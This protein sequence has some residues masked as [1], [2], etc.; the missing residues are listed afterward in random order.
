MRVIVDSGSSVNVI[1]KEVLVKMDSQGYQLETVETD[2]FGFAGHAV[3]PE[4]EIILPLT[5]GTRELRKMV[6]TTFT[7]VDA[8]S[9]YNI[10]LG[11]PAMNK[12]KAVASTY[13]QKI[14]FPVG[15]QEG[16]AQGDQ[17]SSQKCYVEAV[18]VDQKKARREEK[19]VSGSEEMERIVEKGKV[20]FVAEEEQEVVEIGPDK[21]IRVA[22]DLDLSTRELIG[23]SPLIAEYHLNI[24]SGSQPIKQKKRHFGP[25]KDKVIDVQATG[26]W[27][28]CVDFRDLNKACPKDH[29]PLPRID[30]LV[31][32]TSGYELLSFMDAYKGYHQI[33]LAESD[34]DKASFITSGGTFCY[35]FMPLRLENAEAT[36]QCLMN[37]VFEKQLGRNVEV[38]VD[39]ML[40]KSR[41][42]SCFISDLEETFA[43]LMHY[44]IKLNP[45]KCV[46]GVKSG[47]FLGYVV[48]D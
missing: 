24:L 45:S 19:R 16:E 25:E 17:P 47:K 32:S 41:E 34:Q 26:N 2:L 7:I 8:P 29:F 42:T 20:H 48:T 44:E 27:R 21:E 30:Q 12:L 3:Y 38:Y 15:N 39:D 10:I 14:K 9:S 13:H 37:R 31:D 23:I 1:F 33:S 28:M 46:F 11:R 5:L 18:R 43:T 36:Y 40:G 4:G 35:V 6:M 22:R